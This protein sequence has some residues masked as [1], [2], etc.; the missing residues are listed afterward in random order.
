MADEFNILDF[1]KGTAP[2]LGLLGG[3]AALGNAYNR[4]GGIGEAAQQGA[5]LIAQEGLEQTQFQPFT[6]TST[7]GGTFGVTPTKAV[8]LLLLWV[9]HLKSK[10]FK[11]C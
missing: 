11:A 8:A 1:L 9:C 4:L 10:L 6:V 3:S 7:T 5:Q 2:L